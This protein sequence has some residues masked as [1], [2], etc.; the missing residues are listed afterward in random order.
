MPLGETARYD[1][2]DKYQLRLAVYFKTQ[3]RDKNLTE[4]ISDSNRKNEFINPY[5]L[6]T[7]GV[8]QLEAKKSY[9]AAINEAIITEEFTKKELKQRAKLDQ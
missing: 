3:E 2:R 9:S 4:D 8:L 1:K 7:A 5:F 6:T